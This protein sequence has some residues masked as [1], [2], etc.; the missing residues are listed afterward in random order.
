ME[1]EMS[2]WKWHN[3]AVGGRG[4]NEGVR[5]AKFRVWE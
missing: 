2:K 4:S 3:V 1:V 5:N